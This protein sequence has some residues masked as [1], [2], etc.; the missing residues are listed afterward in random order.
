MHELNQQLV[1][2]SDGETNAHDDDRVCPNNCFAA[3]ESKM[4]S[5]LQKMD[6]GRPPPP[7]FATTSTDTIDFSIGCG[8]AALIYVS[9]EIFR[10]FYIDF[11][12]IR[13]EIR[14]FTRFSLPHLAKC[15][16]NIANST[17]HAPKPL[18]THSKLLWTLQTMDLTFLSMAEMTE[19]IEVMTMLL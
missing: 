11:I 19:P 17:P 15:R 14:V 8:F 16:P 4:D 7:A 10:E 12:D 9:L 5:M 18:G 13:R 1:T 3:I 6:A 2:I